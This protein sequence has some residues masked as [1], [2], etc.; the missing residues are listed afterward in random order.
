MQ[1]AHSRHTRASPTPSL[2]GAPRRPN[3]RPANLT[4]RPGNFPGAQRVTP[5]GRP[6]VSASSPTPPSPAASSA[7]S[8]GRSAQ[9]ARAVRRTRRAGPGL[10]APPLGLLGAGAARAGGRAG[11]RAA[12]RSCGGVGAAARRLRGGR[13]RGVA[14]QEGGE[15][16]REEWRKRRGQGSARALAWKSKEPASLIVGSLARVPTPA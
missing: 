13:C 12:G 5:S 14:L 16:K 6:C 4:R 1:G 11:E 7:R 2:P 3:P 10:R 9:P 8:E 15:G